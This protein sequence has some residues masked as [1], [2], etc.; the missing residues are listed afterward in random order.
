MDAEDPV[1]EVRSV[2]PSNGRPSGGRARASRSRSRWRRR[3]RCRGAPI[4][5]DVDDRGTRRT[6]RAREHAER[7]ERRLE[8]PPYAR[9]QR[10]PPVL[11]ERPFHSDEM[12]RG[13]EA[14]SSRS[15]RRSR[16]ATTRR[17]SEPRSGALL[18]LCFGGAVARGAWSCRS[19]ERRR[20][21]SRANCDREEHTSLHAP[22][23][24][25]TDTAAGALGSKNCSSQRGPASQFTNASL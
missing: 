10:D 1:D 16:A 19:V 3:R 6:V 21:C 12:H 23:S 22:T 20:P 2:R 4:G 8:Q 11:A 15:L 17:R 9:S 24:A 18:R 14:R 25:Y 5:P 13:R 7:F